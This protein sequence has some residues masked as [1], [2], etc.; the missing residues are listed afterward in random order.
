[1]RARR[2]DGARG[3]LA[4]RSMAGSRRPMADRDCRSRRRG[5]CRNGVWAGSSSSPDRRS[6]SRSRS[7]PSAGR[8]PAGNRPR[9]C[10]PDPRTRIRLRRS[11]TEVGSGRFHEPGILRARQP[12]S[13]PRRRP[14]HLRRDGADQRAC[15]LHGALTGLA[16]Q[17]GATQAE[18]AGGRW[19]EPWRF[20]G[21]PYKRSPLISCSEVLHSDY[22]KG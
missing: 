20:L 7:S 11:A 18:R 16:A 15:R 3:A 17:P 1:M 21:P 19:T 22:G 10:G 6:R 14:A 8:P 5:R 12:C 2:R 4:R 13:P 9:R